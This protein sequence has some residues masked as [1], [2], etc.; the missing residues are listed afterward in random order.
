MIR[1]IFK[2]NISLDDR[3]VIVDASWEIEENEQY[4]INNLKIYKFKNI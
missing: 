2:W 4:I 3:I 1:I